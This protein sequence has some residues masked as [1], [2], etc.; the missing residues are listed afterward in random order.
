M[1]VNTK[2]MRKYLSVFDFQYAKMTSK[3]ND[4]P[5]NVINKNGGRRK[6]KQDK[7]NYFKYRTLQN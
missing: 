4:P 6:T 3:K 2:I 1:I 7:R 5:K